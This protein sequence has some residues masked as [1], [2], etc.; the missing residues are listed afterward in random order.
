[1]SDGTLNQGRWAG[2]EGRP[3][4][5]HEARGQRRAVR[6]VSSYD[7]GRA[8]VEQ[9]RCDEALL[10]LDRSEQIQGNRKEIR[11]ARKR[12]S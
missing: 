7:L 5:T 4:G 10:Y 6:G 12:C 3:P 2:A 1:V 11:Q 9:G 8:L